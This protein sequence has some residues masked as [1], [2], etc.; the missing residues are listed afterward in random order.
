MA[1]DRAQR[2]DEFDVAEFLAQTRAAQ[3]ALLDNLFLA[4]AN[5]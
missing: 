3:T 5:S 1:G 2:L 4:R